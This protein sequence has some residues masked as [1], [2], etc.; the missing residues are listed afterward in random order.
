MVL[1]HLFGMYLDIVLL[2][3]QGIKSKKELAEM[4]LATKDV[5]MK[6]RYRKESFDASMQIPHYQIAQVGVSH[7]K[8]LHGTDLSSTLSDTDKTLPRFLM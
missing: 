1:V 3:A 5:Q 4:E 6:S 7:V 8:C 2:V